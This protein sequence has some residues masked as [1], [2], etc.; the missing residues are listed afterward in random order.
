MMRVAVFGS[1]GSIGT[2]TL[3]VIEGRPD[4]L[5]V[6]GLAAKSRIDLL[7]AQIARHR[8]RLVAVLD[9]AQAG[10][11]ARRCGRATEVVAGVDGLLRL[12]TH[13]EVD[14]VVVGTS[15]HQMLMPLVRAIQ[16]GKRVALASKEL[17]V[18]AG[19]LLMRL[20]RESGAVLLPVDSEHSALFQAMQGVER[21]HVARIVVTGSGGP[22]W[23]LDAAA[24]SRITREDVL[25]HPKWQMGP[26]ITVD[27]ATLMNKGLELIEAH[28]LFDMPFDRLDVVIHPQAVI[29]GIVELADG[30]CLA[31]LSICDMRLPIQYALSYPERWPSS[32]PRL[33]LSQLGGL[34]FFE[35]D[36]E[37]F[38]CLAL[39]LDATRRGH[40]ACIALSAANDVAVDAYLRGAATFAQIPQII[41]ATLA[42][43]ERVQEPTLDDIVTIDQQARRTASELI[44][45]EAR[46]ACAVPV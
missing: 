15:G 35:P 14:V 8:P 41:R 36:L 21:S 46:A 1:T 12:A 38:P 13:P 9:E 33:Q 42:E 22:L 3:D 10:T 34:Q 39:A 29:H 5:A 16:A 11:L 30:S 24:I 18:A 19:G 32:L 4:S 6:F 20:A 44:A 37:R 7:D 28:W 25:R 40:S 43:H 31:H 45:S 2:S 17:L 26:K 23:K 27:S